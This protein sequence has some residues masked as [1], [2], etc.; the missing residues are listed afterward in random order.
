MSGL[1]CL[2]LEGALG[3]FSAAV[4]SDAIEISDETSGKDALERGLSVVENV[5]RRVGFAM[6]DLDVLA[7][8]TGPGSFTGLRIAVSYAKS[9]ALAL[10]RPLLGIS[11]YDILEYPERTPPVLAVVHGRA[12]IACARLRTAAGETVRCGTYNEI[13][14]MVA[15]SLSPGDLPVCGSVEGVALRLGERGFTV[16]PCPSLSPPALGVARIAAQRLAD[17]ATSRPAS[18]HDVRPDYGE[19]PAAEVRHRASP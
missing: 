11:S 19:L 10:G 8:G 17:E 9:L 2:A 18:P 5:L 7:V 1:R 4:R 16:R 12:G 13:V 15:G 6:R 14:A 3:P